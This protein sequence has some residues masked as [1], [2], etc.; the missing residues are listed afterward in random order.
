M[1]GIFR[2]VHYYEQP[3]ILKV[4]NVSKG[5]YQVTFFSQKEEVIVLSIGRL[6]NIK[7]LFN[8]KLIYSGDSGRHS[9]FLK[10]LVNL[11]Q[12]QNVVRIE[13]D[14]KECVQRTID[15]LIEPLKKQ[16]EGFFECDYSNLMNE[17]YISDENSVDNSFCIYPSNTN[18]LDERIDVLV[19]DL[20]TSK[21]Q[22]FCV[23]YGQNFNV[24]IFSATILEICV[25]DKLNKTTVIKKWYKVYDH[26]VLIKDLE[27]YHKGTFLYDKL[28]EMFIPKENIDYYQACTFVHIYT[29]LL[30]RKIEERIEFEQYV[31][32]LDDNYNDYV[33]VKPKNYNELKAYPVILTIATDYSAYEIGLFLTR[34]I[35]NSE[36][37]VILMLVNI[38]GVT[39]GSYIGEAFFFDVLNNIQKNFSI[40]NKKIMLNGYSNGAYAVW[41][42]AERHPDMI[43]SFCALSGSAS[44]DYLSN[45]EHIPFLAVGS[46]KDY[47]YFTGHYSIQQC[48]KVKNEQTKFITFETEEHSGFYWYYLSKSILKW[49]LC[50]EK[51]MSNFS[52]KTQSN[53]NVDTRYFTIIKTL[54]PKMHASISVET[55]GELIVM[56]LSNVKKI[57][58]KSDLIKNCKKVQICFDG[59]KKLVDVVNG[60]DVF[61]EIINDIIFAS[62]GFY[63]KKEPPFECRL[64]DIYYQPVIVMIEKNDVELEKTA[65][66]FSSPFSSGWNEKISVKYPI[67]LAEDFE[68]Y[69]QNSNVVYITTEYGDKLL[70]KYATKEGI[71]LE[72]D[73]VNYK[74][75]SY[76]GE[77]L[78]SF[79]VFNGSYEI[80]FVYASKKYLL[81]KSIFTRHLILPSKVNDENYVFNKRGF[82]FSGINYYFL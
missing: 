61:V 39:M 30:N 37:N 55:Y 1:S 10:F 36:N 59:R 43:S 45:I 51:D 72:K 9:N 31:S 57:R 46:K 4:V 62:S 32:K 79:I 29:S 13:L 44:L 41:A 2:D 7:L 27:L 76:S 23:K 82:I 52:Y 38:K 11:R 80:L 50:S 53:S 17:L 28:C 3:M 67:Y 81:N 69:E 66:N 78:V 58:L 48:V 70:Q 71:K 40:T 68:K 35:E 5:N 12:G 73:Y 21:T 47:E 74:N 14:E 24:K 54:S 22:C 56:S 20:L 34:A 8:E 6:N 25:K 15:V 33:V 63:E 77:Y 18:H 26:K 19:R 64:L 75:I 42:I 65:K 49:F 60:K 16:L